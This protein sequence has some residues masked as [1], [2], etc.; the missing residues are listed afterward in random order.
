M[1]AKLALQLLPP[2]FIALLLGTVSQSE[3]LLTRLFLLFPVH[4]TPIQY[5]VL[6]NYTLVGTLVF[7]LSTVGRFEEHKINDHHINLYGKQINLL[8]HFS[9]VSSTFFLY[10]TLTIVAD[11]SYTETVVKEGLKTIIFS[12]TMVTNYYL[13]F[14]LAKILIFEGILDNHQVDGILEDYGFDDTLDDLK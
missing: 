13:L 12:L 4:S 5:S 7:V 1:N 8:R 14:V 3:P 6:L 9:N 2:A 11:N 10:A